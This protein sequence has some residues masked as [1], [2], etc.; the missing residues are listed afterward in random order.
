MS[1]TEENLEELLNPDTSDY[2]LHGKLMLARDYMLYCAERIIPKDSAIVDPLGMLKRYEEVLFGIINL[3]SI[4][5]EELANRIKGIDKS[6]NLSQNV[7][8]LGMIATD[9]PQP[10]SLANRFL[11]SFKISA[12]TSIAGVEL[13][14]PDNQK[15]H[16]NTSVLIE[17][18]TALNRVGGL[19]GAASRLAKEWWLSNE[20]VLVI[21]DFYD[22]RKVSKTYLDILIANIQSS[23]ISDERVPNNVLKRLDDELEEIRQ[24]LRKGKTSWNKVLSRLS[25]VVMILA[26]LVT[27]GAGTDEAYQ[28]SLKA[29]DYVSNQSIS[30]QNDTLNT[31]MDNK[32]ILPPDSTIVNNNFEDDN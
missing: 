23:I 20:D 7:I 11:Q 1:F 17:I 28:N 25:Q 3:V 9:E 19:C 4:F 13:Q 2:R 14:F 27:I 26:A 6:L 24:E 12:F 16:I 18:Q 10:F 30:I 32:K 29:F 22:P 31:D 5:N 8:R 15:S 21:D